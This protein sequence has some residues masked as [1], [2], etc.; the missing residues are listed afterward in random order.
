VENTISS[1][2]RFG[3]RGLK[4]RLGKR[5]RGWI[6]PQARKNLGLLRRLCPEGGK[7]MPARNTEVG[8]SSAVEL[9]I[10]GKSGR[11]LAKTF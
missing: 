5:F 6:A 1:V 4:R 3:D 10:G 7:G 2:E 9:I 11:G 8:E